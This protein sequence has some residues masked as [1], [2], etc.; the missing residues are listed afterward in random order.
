MSDAAV[1]AATGH[2]W[3]HWHAVLDA[4]GAAALPHKEI[5]AR[6]GRVHT[7]AEPLR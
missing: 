2:G 1:T 5:A 3:K 7:I 4:M 6:L